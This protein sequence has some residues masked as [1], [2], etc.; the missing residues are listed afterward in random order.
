[1]SKLTS[2][3]IRHIAEEITAYRLSE[4]K[5][6]L[7]KLRDQVNATN[8]LISDWACKR[9]V[10]RHDVLWDYIDELREAGKDE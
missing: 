9:G 8:A 6:L 5:R 1:M 3:E 2:T 4:S 7:E 10:D